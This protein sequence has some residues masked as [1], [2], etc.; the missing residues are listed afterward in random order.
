MLCSLSFKTIWVS[1]KQ[2][3]AILLFIVVIIYDNL[4]NN[5]LVDNRGNMAT[6]LVFDMASG[7]LGKLW[8]CGKLTMKELLGFLT[9]MGPL[10]Q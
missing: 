2:C 9:C 4:V 1:K 7:V 5:I 8:V 10:E 6:F 3:A